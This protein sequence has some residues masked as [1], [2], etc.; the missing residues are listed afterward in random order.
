MVRSATTHSRAQA[1]SDDINPLSKELRQSEQRLAKLRKR[2][3]EVEAAIVTYRSFDR[4]RHVTRIEQLEHEIAALREQLRTCR[5]RHAE[6]ARERAALL[7]QLC[8][9]WNPMTW[10]STEQADLRIRIL[11]LEAQEH[12]AQERAA[13][14][15]K[16]LTAKQQAVR[17][18]RGQLVAHDAFDLNQ[19]ERE[20]AHTIAE[21]RRAESEHR[22]VAAAWERV[23]QHIA[24]LREQ[25]AETDREIQSLQAQMDKAREYDEDLEQAAT[26]YQRAMIHQD[27][28]AYFGNGSPRAVMSQLRKRL[29]H[30]QRTR[31]KLRARITVEVHRAS[32]VIR[33]LIIDGNNLCY[34]GSSFVGLAPLQALLSELVGEYSVTVVFDAAIRYQTKMSEDQLRDALPRGALIHVVAP[35]RCADE[36]ILALARGDSTA[37]VLSNDT[38]AEYRDEDAVRSKRIL[39]HDILRGRVIVHDLGITVPYA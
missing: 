28:Q 27:C 17:R 5:D 34:E 3:S 38:F 31:D 11:A 14:T 20:R 16:E 15:R 1:H 37:Y 9:W 29:N 19:H 7:Q 32:R 13:E 10:F 22:E 8:S 12:M 2:A 39:R 23:E 36:T 25:L 26:T 33:S 30:L 24:P 35:N 21:L 6:A 4:E 18:L